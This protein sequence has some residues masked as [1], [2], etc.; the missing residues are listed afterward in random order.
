MV[1]DPHLFAQ[2]QRLLPV[3]SKAVKDVN[4]D[5]AGLFDAAGYP[6]FPPFA[7]ETEMRFRSTHALCFVTAWRTVCE[8]FS[9]LEQEGEGWSTVRLKEVLG[10]LRLVDLARIVAGTARFDASATEAVECMVAAVD[11]AVVGELSSL[12]VEREPARDPVVVSVDGFTD[13]SG[14]GGPN[15]KTQ[16]LAVVQ[17]LIRLAQCCCS[18][19]I[20]HQCAWEKETSYGARLLQSPRFGLLEMLLV[21]PTSEMKMIGTGDQTKAARCVYELICI[22]NRLREVAAMQS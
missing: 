4:A 19:S 16:E 17:V 5:Y 2:R 20:L 18:V 9:S 10:R 1:N 13:V 14:N 7:P 15:L 11:D 3:F 12:V 6:A 21:D 8:Y 22:V